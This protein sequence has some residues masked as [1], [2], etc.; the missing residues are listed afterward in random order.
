MRVCGLLAVAVV[1]G[2]ADVKAFQ[3]EI[4]SSDSV[5]IAYTAPGGAVV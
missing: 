5:G 4:H 2:A 3:A 1:A